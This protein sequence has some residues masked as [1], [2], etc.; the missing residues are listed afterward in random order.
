MLESDP[1]DEPD[2]SSSSTLVTIVY[3]GASEG[4]AAVHRALVAALARI[5]VVAAAIWSVG[6]GPHRRSTIPAVINVTKTFLA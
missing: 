1:P 2:A 5:G 3:R 6:N 4:S